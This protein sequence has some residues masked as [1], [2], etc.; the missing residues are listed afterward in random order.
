MLHYMLHYNLQKVG[1]NFCIEIILQVTTS[2]EWKGGS[3][4]CGEGLTWMI[5]VDLQ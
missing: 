3:W 1:M 2:G 4:G 5:D